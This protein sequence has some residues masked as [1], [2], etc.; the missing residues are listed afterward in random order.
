MVTFEDGTSTQWPMPRFEQMG[1]FE[2]FRKD[3]FRKWA[4]DNAEWHNYKQFWP[5]FA[6]YIG[7]L[8]YSA[9]G[10]KPMMLMMTRYQSDVPKPETGISRLDIQKR[11]KYST[12]FSYQF[13]PG[14]FQQ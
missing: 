8:H 9:D 7:R 12:L 3:K 10:P 13:K 5:E 2:K 6:R 11:Y 4:S 1:D 14:D